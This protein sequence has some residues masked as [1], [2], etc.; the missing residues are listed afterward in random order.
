TILFFAAFFGWYP[1]FR[2]SLGKFPPP[3]RLLLKLL[4]FNLTAVGCEL[5]VIRVLAPEAIEPWLPAVLL[6]G[7]NL[8]FL[9][10]DAI[11]PR[12]ELLYAVRLRKLL[13]G[14]RPPGS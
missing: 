11:L 13:F 6:I 10:Y 7:G 5:L 14:R 8:A 4:V 1:A 2:E 9:L 3:V 12:L